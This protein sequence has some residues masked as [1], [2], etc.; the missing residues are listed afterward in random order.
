VR[1]VN[2][3]TYVEDPQL[4]TQIRPTHRR[5][6]AQLT[7]AGKLVAGGPFTDGSGGLFIYE[8]ESLEEAKAIVAADPYQTEGAFAHTELKAW[9]VVTPD[10][11]D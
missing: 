5:Y 4:V 6:T 8:A 7:A 9:E 1:F 2:Y 11:E 10:P 3:A